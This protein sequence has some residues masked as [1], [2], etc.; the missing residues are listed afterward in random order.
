[1]NSNRTGRPPGLI[2]PSV[3]KPVITTVEQRLVRK[4]LGSLS[5]NDQQKL[6][7]AIQQIIA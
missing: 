3:V 7:A 6:R 5:N 1:L 2:K 4:T